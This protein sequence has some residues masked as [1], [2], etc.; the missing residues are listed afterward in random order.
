[1]DPSEL[2]TGLPAFV[3]YLQRQE[4][5]K[6]EYSQDEFRELVY[7]R[8]EEWLGALVEKF[9]AMMNVL[10][11]FKCNCLSNAEAVQDTSLATELS[12]R[13]VTVKRP[14]INTL[15]ERYMQILLLDVWRSETPLQL[16]VPLLKN[17]EAVNYLGMM[18]C[19]IHRFVGH[20]VNA[21]TQAS[22]GSDAWFW[23]ILCENKSIVK[24]LQ[25]EFMP[26]DWR[27]TWTQL[28]VCIVDELF[29]PH[30]RLRWKDGHI[31][32]PG[33][34]KELLKVHDEAYVIGHG[35]LLQNGDRIAYGMR[36]RIVQKVSKTKV[37]LN[38]GANLVDLAMDEVHAAPPGCRRVLSPP[39][40]ASLR[41][42]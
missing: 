37:R 27:G 29:V 26:P 35:Q 6:G 19:D 5:G 28:M 24:S 12:I 30:G 4:N 25:V 13:F 21:P 1:M 36:G 22:S 14:V 7:Q 34:N 23:R 11:E 17:D 40:T 15:L 16:V 31:A 3:A 39:M 10:R 20:S 18:M 33:R 38:V 9:T 42:R 8:A 41:S 32:L 2:F